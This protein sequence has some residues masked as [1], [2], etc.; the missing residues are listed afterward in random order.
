MALAKKK[1]NSTRLV[2][3]AVIII[4]AGGIGYLLFNQ[5]V[6]QKDA[7]NGN[8]LNINKPKA[9]ITNFGES[10]LNDSRF[11]QLKAYDVSVNVNAD[12]DGGQPNPFQ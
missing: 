1:S 9:V 3:I 7:T 5:L 2:V 8:A 12:T 6:L 4:A 11:S 10:I